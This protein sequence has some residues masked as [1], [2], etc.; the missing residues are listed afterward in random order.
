MIP[1]SSPTRQ[2]GDW[3]LGEYKPVHAER[4]HFPSRQKSDGDDCFSAWQAPSS[5][6]RTQNWLRASQQ[7]EHEEFVRHLARMLVVQILGSRR[8]DE[9][10]RLGMPVGR[11]SGGAWNTDTSGHSHLGRIVLA[12]D[13]PVQEMLTAGEHSDW[14]T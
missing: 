5:I 8:V 1:A 9:P 7:G 6:H 10:S 4:F 12:K 14:R 3:A 2:A 13:P 11:T